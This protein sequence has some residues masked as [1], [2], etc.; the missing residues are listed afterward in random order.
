MS[1]PAAISVR[2]LWL[3][4]ERPDGAPTQVLAGIDLEVAQGEFVCILGPSGCGK[5]TLLNVVGG[6]LRPTRGEVR[7]QGEPVRGPDRRRIFVFQENGVFPWLTVEENVGFGI[8]AVPREERRRTIAHYLEMVGLVG[9]EHAYPRQ[10]SGGMRQRVEI[11]RALAADPDVLY[12][13]EPFGAL[14]Y[15]TRLKLRADLLALWRRERKTILF[16]TH[17][18]DEAVQLADRV[19]VLGA[20]PARIEEILPIEQPRPRVLGAPEYLRARAE[21]FRALGVSD[22]T[23]AATEPAPLPTGAPR[24]ESE[25]VDVAIVGGGPAGSVLASYLGPAGIGHVLL[26]RAVHPRRHVGE[27]LVCSTTRVFEEIGFLDQLESSG[28]VRKHGALFSLDGGRRQVALPFRAMPELGIAQDHTYHVDRARFDEMLLAHAGARGS[29]IRQGVEVEGIQLEGG[30]FASVRLAGGGETLRARIVADASGRASLLGNQLRTRKNDPRLTQIAVHGWFRDVERG[31]GEASDWIHVHVLDAPRSWVWQIPISAGVT[32]VGIVCEGH[33]GLKAA[34]SAESFFARTIASH[35]LLSARMAK[36]TAVHP[37]QVEGSQSYFA[38]CAAGPGWIAVGDA[39]QFVDPVFSSGVSVAAESARL[40]AGAIRSALGEPARA[41]EHFAAYDETMR[42][43][44]EV[45]RE[46]I[47]LFYRMPAVFLGLLEDPSSR[48]ALQ[49]LLQG[50]VF[51]A[52]DAAG[53]A[54]LSAR[55]LEL[56]RESVSR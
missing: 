13:D 50:R 23:G 28:F 44:G 7:V 30:L 5:S 35:P 3:E 26:D 11:A 27:S 17:D 15:L 43:G 36:A 22:A 19:V 6:F 10:L 14:D 53:L 45:W 34:E 41:A 54:E 29:R 48:A 21:L 49:S 24:S 56:E 47:L 46:L 40:A 9:F 39:A 20:R 25:S 52:R 1:E 8:G 4:F 55:A 51:E 16:V 31:G 33:S 42:R 12:M 18:I 38:E 32:S 2:D 37:L